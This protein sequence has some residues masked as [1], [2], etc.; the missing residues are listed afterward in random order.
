VLVLIMVVE[1]VVELDDIEAAR[2]E[3]ARDNIPKEE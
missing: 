2:I 3:M 1:V